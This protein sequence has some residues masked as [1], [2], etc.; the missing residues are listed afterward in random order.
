[1]A[2]EEVLELEAV[3]A[4]VLQRVP[5]HRQLVALLHLACAA[6]RPLVLTH[7]QVHIWEASAEENTQDEKDM[8]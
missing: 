3:G 2:G 5:F 7:Q 4:D 8:I 1:M 6:G